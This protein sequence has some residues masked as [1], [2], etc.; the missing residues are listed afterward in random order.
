MKHDKQIIELKQV[1][2]PPLENPTYQWYRDDKPIKGAR[3]ATYTTRDA[4]Y[5]TRGI[6]KN[7]TCRVSGDI[8]PDSGVRNLGE[9]LTV[10][11]K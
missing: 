10:V 1:D 9:I 3:Q 4:D 2:G 6:L 11:V 8:D 7:I 5:T